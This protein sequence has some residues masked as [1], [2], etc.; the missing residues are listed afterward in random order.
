[1]TLTI[2]FI[3]DLYLKILYC[4]LLIFLIVASCKAPQSEFTLDEIPLIPL[5]K[6]VNKSE[7]FLNVNKIQSILIFDS[8][9]I[10]NPI[11]NHLKDFWE[12]RCQWN[13]LLVQRVSKPQIYYFYF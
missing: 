1:M 3:N 4:I 11:A 12:M 13:K 2:N 8:D 7:E 6:I 9:K 5:P 10:L